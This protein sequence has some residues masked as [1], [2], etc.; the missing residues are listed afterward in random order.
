MIRNPPPA[1]DRKPT[2][3]V[4]LNPGLIDQWEN[5]LEK[6]VAPGP[7]GRGARIVRHHAKHKQKSLKALHDADYM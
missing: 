7:D 1:N 3:I 2:L 6:H 5:E 4:T